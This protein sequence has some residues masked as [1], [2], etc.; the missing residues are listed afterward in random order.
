MHLLCTGSACVM[1]F[2]MLICLSAQRHAQGEVA[3][4]VFHT[5]VL[6]NGSHKAAYTCIGLSLAEEPKTPKPNSRFEGEQAENY[7]NSRRSEQKL[8][9]RVQ[10]RRF[11][12]VANKLKKNSNTPHPPLP[13]CSRT[14]A[15]RRKN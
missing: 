8:F 10:P 13:P 14:L 1:R 2:T 15:R 5:P 3:H 4:V 11:A 12:C 7:A 9:C 6:A